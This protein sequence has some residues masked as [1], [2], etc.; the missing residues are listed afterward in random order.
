MK[1]L[2]YSLFLACF[3]IMS[4]HAQTRNQNDIIKQAKKDAH[5]F[6]LNDAD[7]KRFRHDRGL[8]ASTILTKP[9]TLNPL[10]RPVPTQPNMQVDYTSDF[11]KPTKA[12]TA[13]TALLSDSVYV[14][15]FR[16]AAYK[17]TSSRRTTGHYIAIATAI[18][19][20][21]VLI[22][23]LFVVVAPNSG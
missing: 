18:A 14:K 6:I 13:D 16:S 22:I 15:A 10:E 11:F 2:I 1:C 9:F 17:N 19:A 3:C 12:T 8:D 21:L 4:L 20:G 23:G 5:G 7:L